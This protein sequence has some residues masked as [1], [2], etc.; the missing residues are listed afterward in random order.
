MNASALP[1]DG[2]LTDPF[3][4]AADLAARHIRFV[5]LS[6]QRMRE[7]Y[8][9]IL[10]WLR[11]HATLSPTVTL[12][13][14]FKAAAKAMGAGPLTISR[15]RVCAEMRRIFLALGGLRAMWEILNDLELGQHLNLPPMP[16]TVWGRL[17][18]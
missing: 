3:G 16:T 13:P 17:L 8:L 10:R 2:E 6:E 7:D 11:S 4:G 12:D 5:D 1:L 9:R 15:E 14:A 18:A